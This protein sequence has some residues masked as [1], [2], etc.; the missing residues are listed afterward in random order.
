MGMSVGNQ[1]LDGGCLDG[2]SIGIDPH[3]QNFRALAAIDRKHAVR[4]HAMKW[5]LKIQVVVELLVLLRIVFHLHTNEP[6]TFTVNFPHSLPKL[7]ILAK[8]FGQNMAR[9]Q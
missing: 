2:L 1:E 6:A 5:L 3:A 7:W 8:L 4:R 9:S